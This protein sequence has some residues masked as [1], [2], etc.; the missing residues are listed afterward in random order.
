M[1]ESSN[2]SLGP[3]CSWVFGFHSSCSQESR[4]RLCWR[5]MFSF[6]PP[7][8]F[9]WKYWILLSDV[10]KMCFASV[11]WIS[12]IL[13]SLQ[14]TLYPL[15]KVGH[16][17]PIK[18]RSRGLIFCPFSRKYFMSTCSDLCSVPTSQEFVTGVHWPNNRY[19][20]GFFVGLYYQSS[21]LAISMAFLPVRA[22]SA[23][24]SF[25]S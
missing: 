18:W 10:F 12:G 21:L 8:I 17:Q 11:S 4:S 9:F 1:V 23:Q 7:M 2:E 20:E 22:P 24:L 13:M 16:S 19:L 14:V 25:S 5:L 3:I 6:K 15:V